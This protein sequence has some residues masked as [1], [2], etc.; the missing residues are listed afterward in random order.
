MMSRKK[1]TNVFLQVRHGVRIRKSGY[2]DISLTILDL[3][4]PPTFNDKMKI[5]R[6][7][8][9][10]EKQGKRGKVC[11]CRD[12]FY[13]TLKEKITKQN[14]GIQPGKQTES[15]KINLDR[16]WTWFREAGA[17]CTLSLPKDVTGSQ[18]SQELRQIQNHQ[19]LNTSWIRILTAVTRVRFGMSGQ[20][21]VRGSSFLKEKNSALVGGSGS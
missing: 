8:G 1:W 4:P 16:G 14:P 11:H 5:P 10:Q 19:S 12:S 9:W 6:P 20:C 17:F 15:I 21:L 7:P 13:W 2:F 18:V 3:A